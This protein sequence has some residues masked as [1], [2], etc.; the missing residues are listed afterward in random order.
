ML[1]G[2]E[3]GWNNLGELKQHTLMLNYFDDEKVGLHVNIQDYPDAP[4]KEDY[5]FVV[6]LCLN[7][8]G[9]LP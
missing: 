7:D 4:S 6:A 9:S 2:F 8:H 5:S 3:G 1:E